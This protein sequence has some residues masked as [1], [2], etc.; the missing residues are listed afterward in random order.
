[1]GLDSYYQKGLDGLSKRF[2]VDVEG[3]NMK[4]IIRTSS[5][6]FR[7]T[8]A[9]SE[10]MDARRL[11]MTKD[12]RFKQIELPC[13]AAEIAE[14]IDK[15]EVNRL[16][17]TEFL[18]NYVR[19]A[20]DSIMDS[21]A[22]FV[23]SLLFP[24][25]AA[26]GGAGRAQTRGQLMQFDFPLQNGYAGNNTASTLNTYTYGGLN[27]ASNTNVQA[28]NVGNTTT[29]FTYT[30]AGLHE[31]L[32]MP[33]RDRGSNIDL[34]MVGKKQYV[35]MR[36]ELEDEI[37][38]NPSDMKANNEFF[39]MSNGIFVLYEPQIDQM[40]Y[41]QI[42]VGDSSTLRFGISDSVEANIKLIEN[43]PGV[44][45]AHL[46]QAYIEHAF[47]NEFPRYWGRAFNVTR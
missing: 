18:T 9:L 10:D 41:E 32:I 43:V 14:R 29:A 40:D 12:L 8:D 33:L 2:K 17:D 5:P 30:W 36:D 11:P 13:S 38:R 15:Y 39:T 23:N 44:P 19:V 31:N 24:A 7:E 3:G 35:F 1:M 20:S 21:Y 27:L 28:I 16:S 46:L 45:S 42:F 37:H 22:Q 25:N 34:I 6:S 26:V 47:W 4:G